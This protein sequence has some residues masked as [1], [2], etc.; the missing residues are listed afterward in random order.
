MSTQLVLGDRFQQAFTLAS[1]LHAGQTRKQSTVPYLAHLL[2][3]AALV[4]EYGGCE[5]E[6][7]AALLHDAPEDQGGEE[8]LALIRD[9]FGE[10]VARIV[11]DCSDTFEQPKPPW[12]QR[13]QA[14]LAHLQHAEADSC[15]VVLADKLYNARSLVSDLH[16][17]GEAAWDKFNGGKEGTLWYYQKMHALL[18]AKLPG[19]L[20]DQLGRVINE[21]EV[22]SG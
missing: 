5:D 13:K 6:A 18:S 3:V 17:Q 10:R 21:I 11:A 22:L 7:V 2:G 20:A 19:E 12:R 15:R 9:Q 4:L 16:R 8:T 1:Q 14:H